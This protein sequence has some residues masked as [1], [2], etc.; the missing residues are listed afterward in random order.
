MSIPNISPRDRIM[1]TVGPLFYREGYRAIGVD[2]IIAESGV[3][4]ATFYKHFPAKDDV[5]VAW[6]DAA[7]NAMAQHLPGLDVPE[8][9]FAY[10]DHLIDVAKSPKCLGCTFQV[11]AAEFGDATHP[12]HIRAV[13]I[14]DRVIAQ[15][16]DRAA[17]QGLNDPKSIANNVYLFIEGIWASVR[18]LQSDAPLDH[19]K[20]AV[21][22]LCA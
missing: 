22:K 2:R 11:A 20:Q 16:E 13:Q 8:P 1:K 15:L 9:L 5:I 19:A 7:E 10:V 3:A 14:K 6:L 12:A 4:K 21:R 18:M 17:A